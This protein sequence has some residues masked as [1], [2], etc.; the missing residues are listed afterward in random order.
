[1][2]RWPQVET[3][4]SASRSCPLGRRRTYGGNAPALTDL[5]GG[6]VQVMVAS[7]PASI[8]YI[9]S[10]QLRALAVTSSTRLEVLSDIPTVGELHRVTRRASGVASARP[11]Q[12]PPRSSTS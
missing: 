5:L 11:R 6:L 1:M 10:G 9:R 12:R 8:E 4:G 3:A 2:V 7:M